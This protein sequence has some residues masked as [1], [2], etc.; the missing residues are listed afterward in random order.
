MKRHAGALIATFACLVAPTYADDTGFAASHDLRKEGGRTCMSEH[1]H[2]A[3]GD[4]KT[5]A[6]ARVAALKEW[7]V[8]TAG[9]YGSD[10]A[11]WS[12]SGS[13]KTAYTKAETGWTATVESRP[14]K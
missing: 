2:S 10:W 9:E 1:A 5:K 14:C 11:N 12:K 13:Q 7:Y 8:Y 6:S 4:G 3:S